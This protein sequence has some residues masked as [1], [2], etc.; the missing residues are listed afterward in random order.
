MN[1]KEYPRRTFHW[2]GLAVS[3][4][5]LAFA[6]C[7]GGAA[8]P[9]AQEYP[10]QGTVTAVDRSKPSVKLD[11][12]EIRSLMKAMEMD[13]PAENATI[14]EGINAVDQVQGRLQVQSGKY[15]ITEL[16]KR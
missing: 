16:E 1:E 4:V 15:M 7:N 5:P 3:L 13:Y 14:L 9:A 6:G 10:I 11:H 12:E 8:T 2:L